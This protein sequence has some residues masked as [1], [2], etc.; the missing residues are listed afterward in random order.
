MKYQ[1]ALDI[2]GLCSSCGEHTSLADSCCGASVLHEG[3][4]LSPD[5]IEDHPDDADEE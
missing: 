1:E 3:G 5:D 4:Y 2:I